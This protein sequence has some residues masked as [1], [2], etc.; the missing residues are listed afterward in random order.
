MSILGKWYFNELP[1]YLI[2][3]LPVITNNKN[4]PECIFSYFE[5]FVMQKLL[6]KENKT[7]LSSNYVILTKLC[8]GNV[9]N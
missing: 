6:P 7:I 2:I 4:K 3:L 8:I 1:V 9:Y 5:K